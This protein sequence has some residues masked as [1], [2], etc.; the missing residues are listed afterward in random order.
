MKYN[1]FMK[2]YG[3]LENNFIAKKT[4]NVF[5]SGIYCVYDT[6]ICIYEIIIRVQKGNKHFWGEKIKNL[7]HAF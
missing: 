5:E 2:G 4:E 7:A 1:R 3:I 6:Y